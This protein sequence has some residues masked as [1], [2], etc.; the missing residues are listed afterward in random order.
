MFKTHDSYL[1]PQKFQFYDIG[2][3]REGISIKEEYLQQIMLGSD[4]VFVG[5]K[6]SHAIIVAFELTR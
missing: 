1:T 4:G 5:G 3:F 2:W 6:D